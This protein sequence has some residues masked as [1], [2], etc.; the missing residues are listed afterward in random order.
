MLETDGGR[1]GRNQLL[2]DGSFR[3]VPTE[4]DG[5]FLSTGGTR[6]IRVARRSQ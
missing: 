1:C 3:C 2:T 6:F 5:A 4:G